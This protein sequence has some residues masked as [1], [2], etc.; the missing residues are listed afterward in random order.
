MEQ[1]VKRRKPVQHRARKTESLIL[2]SAARLLEQYGLD[3]FNTNRLAQMSGVSVG[4]IYQYFDDKRAI[5]LA[6]AQREQV[7]AIQEI[8]EWLATDTAGALADEEFPRL[9]AIVRA[10][11]HTFGGR[12]R[13]HR[14]L[15]ELAL[16]I[17]SEQPPDHPVSALTELLTI[18]AVARPEGAR[19]ALADIDTFVLTRAVFGS[20][21]A[22]LAGDVRLL[23]KPQ[24]EDAL[25]RLIAGFM[26]SRA[27]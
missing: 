11:L 23:R 6:L 4:T 7:R 17:E 5:L 9:R 25:V 1:S 2:E 26:R 15:I 21:R 8:R 10:M 16:Q 19:L 18:E 20:I 24:Y 27:L 14:V 3:V 12:Q 22:A 13:V